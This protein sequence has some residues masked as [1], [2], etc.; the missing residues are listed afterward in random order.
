M[1][2][3]IKI[4]SKTMCILSNI[5]KYLV[6]LALIVMTCVTFVEVIRRYIFGKSFVWG[7]ELSKFLIVAITFLGGAA[8]YRA[9]DMANFDLLLTKLEVKS[10]RLK[11]AML[12]INNVIIIAICIY[13]M[14]IGYKYT[15]SPMVS[16]MI[17]SGLKLNMSVIYSTIPIGF[18]MIMLFSIEKILIILFKDS[19]IFNNHLGDE[20][21][22]NK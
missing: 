2:K 4:Y 3:F 18:G 7:E 17:S 5:I 12:L 14:I 16:K 6:A 19:D 15:I 8:A 13:I 22:S 1:K 21:G 9:G 20:G 11:K 10:P